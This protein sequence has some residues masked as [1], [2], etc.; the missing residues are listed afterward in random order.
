[1]NFRKA[2]ALTAMLLL[3]FCVACGNRE[4]SP[5]GEGAAQSDE[6][7]LQALLPNEVAGWTLQ[8]DDI[9]FYV[10]DTLYDLIN[11]GMEIYLVYGFERV[12]SVDYENPEQVHPILIQLYQMA[13]PR[14]AYGIYASERNPNPVIRPIGAEGYIGGGALN[15]WAGNYYV[16]LLTFEDNEELRQALEDIASA[17]AQRIG[18][19]PAIPEMA[20]FP[21]ENQVPYTIRYLA[22][23][24]LGQ[25]YFGSGF[26]AIYSA[27]NRESRLL[28]VF[29]GNEDAAIEALNRYKEF[30]T[31]ERDVTEPGDGGFV[32]TDS[33]YGN[34]AAVRSGDRIFISLGEASADSALSRITATIR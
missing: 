1:M 2:L 11:G 32:G 27:N 7:R 18:D 24:I 29:P 15:F 26:E 25:T 5:R 19:T 21:T 33:F 34:L 28:I 9:R 13:D 31:V 30:S 20:L 22:Q 3:V 10:E 14:N 12:V 23:D 17:I 6:A 4:Q 16:K 8:K